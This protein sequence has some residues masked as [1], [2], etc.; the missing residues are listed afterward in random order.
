MENVKNTIM[1]NKRFFTKLIISMVRRILSNRSVF[2]KHQVI[3]GLREF[4]V[5]V[6]EP[7]DLGKNTKEFA[8]TWK[9]AKL[10]IMSFQIHDSFEI[11]E[12][13]GT[14]PTS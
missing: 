11:R 13:T 8:K 2:M 1:G 3:V 6:K 5:C 10:E 12:C 9:I 4:R 7:E 14:V